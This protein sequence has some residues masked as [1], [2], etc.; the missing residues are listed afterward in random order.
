[1]IVKGSAIL[2]TIALVASGQAPPD[3]AAML[4]RIRHLSP[5]AFKSLPLAVRKTLDARSCRI[6]QTVEQTGP[7]NVIR[8]AF[9]APHRVE[10]AVICAHEGRMSTLV[11]SEHGV[12]LDS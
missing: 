11:L 10:W 1:M 12:V 6:P 2:M 3:E 4:A 5:S 7:E 8:G 9:T